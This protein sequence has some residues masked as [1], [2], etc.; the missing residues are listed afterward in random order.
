VKSTED[1]IKEIDKLDFIIV[2]LY[3]ALGPA[4]DEIID[5]AYDAWERE[6]DR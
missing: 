5:M 4:A 6:N 1:L 2:Y 3:D